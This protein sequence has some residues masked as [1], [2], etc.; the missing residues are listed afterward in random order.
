[1]IQKVGSDGA[2]TIEQNYGE[3]VTNN[4]AEYKALIAALKHIA[5]AYVSVAHDIS[6][7]EISV[8]TDSKLMIGHLASGHKVN[9]PNL[10]PLVE[11]ANGLISQ[12]Y[13][14]HFNHISGVRMKEI[15]GH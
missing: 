8:N 7:V 15:L 5:D 2:L 6:T 3:G 13:R 14:V 9:A 12:F 10:K 11:Q 4:E 1:M